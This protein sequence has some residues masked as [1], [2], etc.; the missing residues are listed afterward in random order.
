M[1]PT[2]PDLL[3]I[4]LATW[5]SADVLTKRDGPFNLA[6][7]FRTRYPLGGLTTCSVCASPYLAA[8]WWG[9]LQT[10]FAPLAWIIAAAGA[11]LMLG[12]YTGANHL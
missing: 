12:S 7:R 1:T 11:A 3:V 10:P 5:Y 8:L 6:G 9:V 2:L 4:A